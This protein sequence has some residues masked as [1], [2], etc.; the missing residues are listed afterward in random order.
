MDEVLLWAEQAGAE[1]MKFRVLNAEQLAKD[2]NTTL[3]LL[4]A[5]VGGSLV[6]AAKALENQPHQSI[7]ILAAAGALAVWFML[8]SALTLHYCIQTRDF[9]AP[10]NEPKNLYQPTYMLAAL[11]EVELG[12]LQQRIDQLT[13]RNA[14]V[15]TRL[16]RI[17]Y[18]SA[19]APVVFVIAAAVSEHWPGLS[20][21][22][23]A[24][25]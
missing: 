13:K 9:P 5:G 18:A 7:S 6:F 25:G 16:D 22:V 24:A 11:R 3:T 21:L 4:L 1:N 8:L 2:A 12:N 15:A 19:A 17:R 23:L 20:A 10:T 14:G